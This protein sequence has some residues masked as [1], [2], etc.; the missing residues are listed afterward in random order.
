MSGGSDKLALKEDDVSKMLAA[1]THIG[2]TNTDFQMEQYVFKR[3]SDG[4]SFTPL[5]WLDFLNSNHLDI[6]RCPH[7]QHPPHLR[8]AFA[9]CPCHRGYWKPCWCFRH[10]FSPRRSES[11]SEVRL[12]HEID[13]NCW[14]LHPW[15]F[16]QSDPGC[17]PW[18]KALDHHGSPCW[19]PANCWSFIRQHPS[20]CTVQH[21]LPSPLRWH[22]HPMQQQGTCCCWKQVLCMTT[23]VCMM[24]SLILINVMRLNLTLALP[25]SDK[26]NNITIFS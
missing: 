4:K 2:S 18:T 16:H 8:E 15:S 7:H 24:I 26:P 22:W 23:V 6:Y 11:C 25:D 21:W 14:T 12:L 3:R 5:I 19:S 17:F 10:L 13:P 1:T 20:H 9:S